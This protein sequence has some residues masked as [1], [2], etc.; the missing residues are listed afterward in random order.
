M[1]VI[2]IRPRARPILKLLAWL[3]PE[4]YSTRSI[5]ITGAYHSSDNKIGRPRSGSSICLLRVWWQSEIGRNEVLWTINHKNYNFREKNAKLWKEGK[6]VFNNW[7]RRRKHSK[8]TTRPT[9]N[10]AR[11]SKKQASA[12]VSTALN[13]IGW[14]TLNVISLLNCLI[15]NS[16][17]TT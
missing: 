5:T 12:H 2:A 7:Q 1:L 14:S 8:A 3:L 16:P 10:K 9:G 13:V 17:I 4:L 15:T 6:F 11:T